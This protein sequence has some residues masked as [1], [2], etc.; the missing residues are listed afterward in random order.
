VVREDQGEGL[1]LPLFAGGVRYR[2]PL[3]AVF[4]RGAASEARITQTGGSQVESG[5]WWAGI[6]AEVKPW[7]ELTITANYYYTEGLQRVSLL[8]PLRPF[9]TGVRLV[10]D[11]IE[12]A[13]T[14]VFFGGLE[15]RLTKA[16]RVFAIYDR[17]EA[18]ASRTFLLGTAAPT[19]AA[20]RS[21][22]SLETAQ[23]VEAGF[24]YQFW[25]RFETGA[26]YSYWDVDSFGT[27]EGK[28]NIVN[29]RFRFYF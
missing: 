24:V 18:D 25:Q 15:Y 16:L 1:I 14:W 4:V 28:M 2:S 3:F 21:S 8:P 26:A 9:S 19:A 7:P 12:L 5:V 10:G 27:S 22:T 6:G 23:W 17:A 20:I 29:V 11:D 13:R